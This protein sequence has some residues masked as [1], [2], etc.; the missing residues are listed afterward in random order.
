MELM[1]LNTA[2][3]GENSI[4]TVNARDLHIFL[5]VKTDFKHWISRRIEEFDFVEGLDFRSFLTE[6]I[7]GRPAKEY[8]ISIDMAKELSMVQ[9]SAKGK[10]ARQYFIECERIAKAP[11]VNLD[12]PAELRALLLDNVEKV[13]VLEAEVSEMTPLVASYEHLTRTDG[14]LCITDAAK[15]LETRPRELFEFLRANKWV[16]RRAGNAHWV[17][18]Q[19]KIQRGFLD[20]RVHE[21][22]RTDGSSKITEQVRLT[23]KGMAALGKLFAPAAV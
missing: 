1:K 11:A 23:A 7:G 15:V 3:I 18:Y 22:T 13:M 8:A 12:N 21:V 16:Y 5:E 2:R 17:G 4:E 10:E 14:T 19:D 20:H 9:R 6:S